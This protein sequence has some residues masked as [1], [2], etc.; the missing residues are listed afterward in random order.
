MGTEIFISHSSRDLKSAQRVQ[1]RLSAVNF[2][3]W[4]DEHDIRLGVLLR[5]ELQTAIRK[6]KALVLVWS[7]HA[8]H[9]RWVAAEIITAFHLKRPIVCYC[10]DETPLLYFL[11]NSV[12]LT[13]RVPA[14][15]MET[16]LFRSI[17]TSQRKANEVIPVRES[18]TTEQL[19]VIGS[20]TE[21][22]ERLLDSMED[23]K[24]KELT[25]MQKTLD[26]MQQIA[27][28][29]WPMDATILNLAGYHYKN[30]YILKHWDALQAGLPPKDKLLE[31]AER[32]FF[33]ALFGNPFDSSALNGLGSILIYERDYEAAAFFI[34]RAIDLAAKEGVD[35]TAA[36]HDLAQ[37]KWMV[38]PTGK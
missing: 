21:G 10:C 3:T 36:K 23:R 28:K 1:K 35:Y 33:D 7:R 9:S 29:Q 25:A 18:Q 2:M 26:N 15:T 6:C 19:A 37:I 34:Q 24:T 14:K 22:Q 4:L 27:L 16:M 20:L 11:Q 5:K 13:S 32:Y 30:A 12:F 8:L 38:E 31:K 17:T